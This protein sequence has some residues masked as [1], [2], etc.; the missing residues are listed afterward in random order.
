MNSAMTPMT[1]PPGIAIWLIVR[2]S[3]TLLQMVRRTYCGFLRDVDNSKWV[4]SFGSA[5]ALDGEVALVGAYRWRNR[6][7]AY[8]FRR[9]SG[10]ETDCVWQFEARLILY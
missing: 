1:L 6:G 8:I 10:S 9:R 3:M 7:A 4:D 2:G 5:V